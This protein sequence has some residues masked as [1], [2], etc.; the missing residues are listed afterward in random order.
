MAAKVMLH[1]P[2]GAG[3]L[4]AIAGLRTHFKAETHGSLPE[5]SHPLALL[6]CNYLAESKATLGDAI[7]T[8]SSPLREVEPWFDPSSSQVPCH[9]TT[10]VAATAM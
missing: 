1:L 10:L 3:V 4:A 9:A 2:L 7:N 6:H 5:L 8:T